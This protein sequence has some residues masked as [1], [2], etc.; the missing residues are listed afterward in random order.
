M[1]GYNL[2]RD[3]AEQITNDILIHVKWFEIDFDDE[4]K[5]HLVVPSYITV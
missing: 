3:V 5:W 4:N 1:T 2:G